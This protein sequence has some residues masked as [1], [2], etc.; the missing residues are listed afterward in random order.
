MNM[1]RR[2]FPNNRAVE[3]TRSTA[4]LSRVVFLTGAGLSADSGIAAYRG[5]GG[6]YEKIAAE[7]LMTPKM[8]AESPETVHRF[9][10]DRRAALADAL[11]NA[12]HRVLAE[13]GAIYGDRMTHITQNVDDLAERAGYHG[14]IR[15]HGTLTSMRSPTDPETRRDI[16]YA[17]YWDG[18]AAMAPEGG[19]RFTDNTGHLFRPDVVLFGEQSKL[20]HRM[21]LV[22]GALHPDDLLVV[23]G[24]S[25][26]I[27]PVNR[28]TS[29]ADCRKVL[30]NLH[31]SQA[32]DENRFDTVL[33][34]GAAA[35]ADEIM[36]LVTRHL[37]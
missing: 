21:F 1:F 32:I 25:G 5:A 22:M 31:R 27:L 33:R 10:D 35:T 3:P 7:E 14:S 2:F 18:D 16:G 37:G 26:T 12:A 20:Y 23:I 30:V 24:T 34:A 17:R 28:W 6:V 8:L 36:A 11:P 9:C 4:R 19:F 15:I 13:L 29:N